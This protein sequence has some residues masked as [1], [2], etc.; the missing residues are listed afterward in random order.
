MVRGLGY[1]P[2]IYDTGFT[3]TRAINGD[4]FLLTRKGRDRERKQFVILFINHCPVRRLN[5][6]Q[7]TVHH[8]LMETFGR[9][10]HIMN[11]EP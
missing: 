8:T 10:L 7:P 4:Q 1:G 5:N 2:G 6:S 11:T 3:R 9:N